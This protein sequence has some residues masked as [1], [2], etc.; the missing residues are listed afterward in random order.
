[1]LG[2]RVLHLTP[3]YRERLKSKVA[4]SGKEAETWTLSGWEVPEEAVL[5]GLGVGSYSR[6]KG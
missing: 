3:S 2:N 6:E 1:M 5:G 4:E